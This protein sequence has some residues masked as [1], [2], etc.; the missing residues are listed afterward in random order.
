[1]SRV[2]VTHSAVS[3]YRFDSYLLQFH[4]YLGSNGMLAACRAELLD[5]QKSGTRSERA[6]TTL[7][8]VL[9]LTMVMIQAT[10]VGSSMR[11]VAENRSDERIHHGVVNW[12]YSNTGEKPHQ[13]CK[14]RELLV[15]YLVYS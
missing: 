9:T 14:L 7:M 6:A 2:T 4:L 12:T 1:M 8:M 10:K 5:T 13:G 3:V 11:L 15:Y